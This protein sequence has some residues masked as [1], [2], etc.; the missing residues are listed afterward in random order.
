[1]M[2]VYLLDRRYWYFKGGSSSATEEGAVVPLGGR[3]R[4][5]KR[6]DKEKASGASEVRDAGGKGEGRG[7]T[8]EEL[9]I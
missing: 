8:G 1:M 9:S 4:V 2:K 6:R 3:Q 5:G 7:A